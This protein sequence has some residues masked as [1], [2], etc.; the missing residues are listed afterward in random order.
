MK[1]MCLFGNVLRTFFSASGSL[2]VFD[3]VCF[4]LILKF[5]ITKTLKVNV[6]YAATNINIWRVNLTIFPYTILLLGWY[7]QKLKMS[8]RKSKITDGWLY[9]KNGKEIGFWLQEKK[10]NSRHIGSTKIS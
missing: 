6:S 8:L 9:D 10:I 1:N 4:S 7:E 3:L 2:F 5:K